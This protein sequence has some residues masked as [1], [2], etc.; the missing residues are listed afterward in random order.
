MS[1]SGSHLLADFTGLDRQLCL[2]GERWI[3]TFTEVARAWR[4]SVIS[5]ESHVFEPPK[6]PGMTAYVL[7]DASHFSVHTFATWGMAALD[8]F[9]CTDRELSEA[10]RTLCTSLQIQEQHV[11]RV[12]TV[13]RFGA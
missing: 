12:R 4:L 8:L 2:D 1:V 7:L 3:R 9:V 11:R 6:L 13:E 5:A 10:F